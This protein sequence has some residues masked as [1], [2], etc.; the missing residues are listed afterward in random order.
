MNIAPLSF[1]RIVKVNAPLN[2]AEKVA[3]LV[4]GKE[5]GPA[6]RKAKGIFCDSGSGEAIALNPTRKQN[7]SYIFSGLDARKAREIETDM[8]IECERACNYYHGDSDLVNAAFADAGD[9][10]C[11]KLNELIRTKRH[12]EHLNVVP[13]NDGSEIKFLDLNVWF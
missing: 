12:A 13:S 4:N 1:G 8:R 7:E 6:A 11:K 9:R 5:N 2:V 3:D 10:A